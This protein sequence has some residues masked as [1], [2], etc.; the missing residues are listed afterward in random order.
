MRL[1]ASRLTDKKKDRQTDNVK[2]TDLFLSFLHLADTNTLTSRSGSTASRAATR[3]GARTLTPS[4]SILRR[5]LELSRMLAILSDTTCSTH[6]LCKVKANYFF[7][8]FRAAP[9]PVLP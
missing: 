7:T 6:L 1:G 8:I 5:L 2:K 4:R 3:L 9:N